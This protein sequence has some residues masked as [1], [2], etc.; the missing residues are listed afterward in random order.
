MGIEV[1]ARRTRV[2]SSSEAVL[3][4]GLLSASLLATACGS[5]PPP[6]K[7]ATVGQ[8]TGGV[9]DY[10]P[11][12]HESVFSYETRIEPSGERGLL[13]LEI[14]RRRP[15]LAELVVA[16]RAQRLNVSSSA[17]ELV[18]GGA[19]LRAPLEE[20]ASWRGDFGRVRVTNVSRTVTVPAG[21]FQKCLETVEEMTSAEGTKRTTT[22]YCPAV[23]I[24]LRE[25]E[26]EQDAQHAIERIELKSFGK[27][28]S[29][30]S[31]IR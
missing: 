21:T 15:E 29:V 24:T 6:A 14:R 19:L 17:I 8:T 25:T 26:V 2:S 20:G 4:F 31:P 9:L 11:L 12:E 13:V 23:G 3:C 1:G 28:F 27:R 22:A 10:L 7:T 18:T 16:G 5:A 30:E